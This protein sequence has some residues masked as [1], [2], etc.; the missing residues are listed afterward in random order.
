MAWSL[1]AKSEA[2]SWCCRLSGMARRTTVVARIAPAGGFVSTSTLIERI[3]LACGDR[4]RSNRSP[5][6]RTKALWTVP[7]Q[8]GFGGP[9]IR[10][11]VKDTPGAGSCP[12]PHRRLLEAEAGDPLS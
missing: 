5:G 2:R 1:P 10:L 11:E 4:L 7:L 6:K 3:S 12:P 9:E 8:V